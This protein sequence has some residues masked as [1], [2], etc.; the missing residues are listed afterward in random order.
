MTPGNELECTHV[1]DQNNN[2]SSN[3]HDNTALEEFKNDP[4]G[5]E[6]VLVAMTRPPEKNYYDGE[7]ILSTKFGGD[8][9]DDQDDEK[10][11]GFQCWQ[12]PVCQSI[13]SLVSYIIPVCRYLCFILIHWDDVIVIADKYTL[14]K[15]H[16]I[17]GYINKI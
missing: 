9:D 1:D 11:Q 14:Y 12:C 4:I 16:R 13:N 17:I 8:N 2:N 3:S 10:K 7:G 5:A 6:T 15:Y